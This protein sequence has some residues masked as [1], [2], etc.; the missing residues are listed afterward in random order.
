MFDFVMG[1][2]RWSLRVAAHAALMRHEYPVRAENSISVL[3]RLGGGLSSAVRR[4][5]SGA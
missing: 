3:R 2:N 4:L 1:M 5:W